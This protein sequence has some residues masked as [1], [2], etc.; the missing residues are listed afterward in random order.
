M[1]EHCIKWLSNWTTLTTNVLYSCLFDLLFFFF[2]CSFSLECRQK[3]PW[4]SCSMRARISLAVRKMINCRLPQTNCFGCTIYIVVLHC[5]K[6]SLRRASMYTV[7]RYQTNRKLFKVKYKPSPGLV[8]SREEQREK[9]GEK[10]N[11]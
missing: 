2:F 3:A 11:I 4:W 1:S 6:H 9:G 8:Y 5:D 10:K 7:L